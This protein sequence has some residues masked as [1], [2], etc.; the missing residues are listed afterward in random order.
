MFL[1]SIYSLKPWQIVN[2]RH[3][4]VN[5]RAIKSY[6]TT[7]YK[8]LPASIAQEYIILNC[9][10]FE[11]VELMFYTN[12]NAYHWW[13]PERTLDSLQNLGHQ[14]AAFPSHGNQALPDYILKDST[15][16]ILEHQL[17]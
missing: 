4:E 9:K 11:D 12:A 17:Q 2:V 16:L 15:I 3:N 8:N 13:F 10:E 14:F 6:N 7:I 5:Y 1:V